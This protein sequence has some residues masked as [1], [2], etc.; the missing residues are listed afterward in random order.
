[1][2]KML[3]YLIEKNEEDIEYLSDSLANGGA[4]DYA[5]Y[6]TAVGKVNGLRTAN[7]RMIDV[8]QK[9]LNGEE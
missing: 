3:R 5:A 9:L 4:K 1:M 7:T 8:L 2:E 6:S